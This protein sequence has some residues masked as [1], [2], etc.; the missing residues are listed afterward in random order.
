M[1]TSDEVKFL[2]VFKLGG[3]FYKPVRQ[4]KKTVTIRRFREEAHLFV[5]GQ[6]VVGECPEGRLLLRITKDTDVYKTFYDLPD[7]S[8]QLDGFV[9]SLDAFAGLKRG[10]YTDLKWEDPCAVIWFEYLE[11]VED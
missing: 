3:G 6:L 5:E 10:F 2:K 7:F 9:D 1:A 11:D 4:N 8:A